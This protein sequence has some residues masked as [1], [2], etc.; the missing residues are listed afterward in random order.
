MRPKKTVWVINDTTLPKQSA[1]SASSAS[2]TLWAFASRDE[3]ACWRR[4]RIVEWPN[5]EEHLDG[6]YAYDLRPTQPKRKGKA[7][8][9]KKPL[10]TLGYVG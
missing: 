1:G 7:T 8:G 10:D 9:R 4:R 2:E 3:A 5:D 6:P